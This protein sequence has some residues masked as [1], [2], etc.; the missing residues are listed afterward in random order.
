MSNFSTAS[1]RH[2]KNA[3]S[4]ENALVLQQVVLYYLSF[5][6]CHSEPTAAEGVT[7][8]VCVFPFLT[9]DC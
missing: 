6:F 8:G 3:S 1:V 9:I 5:Q 7:V 2:K 4:F